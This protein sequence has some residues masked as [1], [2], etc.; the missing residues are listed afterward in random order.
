MMKKVLENLH[1]ITNHH[2]KTLNEMGFYFKF[3]TELNKAK[4][5]ID[6]YSKNGNEIFLT[7]AWNFYA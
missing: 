1:R 2:N 7:Q 4:E 5:L 3:G 6:L